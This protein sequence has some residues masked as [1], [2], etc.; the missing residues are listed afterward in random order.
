MCEFFSYNV[1]FLVV[2]PLGNVMSRKGRPKVSVVIPTYQE[3]D[4]IE[5]LLSQ[6]VE[7]DE[8]PEIMVV[9]GGSVDGT[10][11][12]AR[13][14]ADKVYVVRQRGIAKAR[15][16]GA[17]A[18]SGDILVFIDADVSLPGNILSKVLM[19]FRDKTVVGATC[20]I[21]PRNPMLFELFFFVFYNA[22]LRFSVF[23]KPHSRGE[24]IAV[25]R[26][27]FLR[28]GGFNEELP[29]LEDHDLA[30]RIAKIGRFVFIRDLT[31]HESMRRFRKLGF[32]RVVQ[33]WV[34][35]YISLAIFRKTVTKVWVSVR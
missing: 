15:N 25:R 23:F 29:C 18:S 30:F 3:G 1:M 7:I 9:D 20:N 16:V 10:V 35:N 11:R 4:Y 14:F 21:M 24:F 6:L 32:L 26:S 33:S 5:S 19:S 13:E 27:V 22:L 8:R 12:R 2:F 17:Y 31:V 34:V 28:A